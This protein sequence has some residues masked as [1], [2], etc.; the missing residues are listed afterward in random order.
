ME[1]ALEHELVN[2]QVY[3]EGLLSRKKQLTP[4]LTEIFD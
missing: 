2:N 1:K 4:N 3:I